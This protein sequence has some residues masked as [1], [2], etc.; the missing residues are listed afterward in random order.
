VDH[1]RRNVN[2]GAGPDLALLTIEDHL[3]FALED[4]VE[5][6]GALV[7]MRP[8][9]VDVDGVR[10]SG[11]ILV[12]LA[13][14]AIAISASAPFLGHFVLVAEDEIGGVVLFLFGHRVALS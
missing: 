3:S 6:G 7:K 1:A 4:V 2:H 13:Q 5:F 12:S 9:S 11:H 10:P 14:Q 8:G